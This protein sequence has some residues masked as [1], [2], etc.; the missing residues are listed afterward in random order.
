MLS[1]YVLLL[2]NDSADD[3]IFLLCYVKIKLN[4]RY[5]CYVRLL[6]Y[7]PNFFPNFAV[8]IKMF[9]IS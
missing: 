8:P 1:F 5:S 4:K 3:C 6:P 7:N 9:V 2:K